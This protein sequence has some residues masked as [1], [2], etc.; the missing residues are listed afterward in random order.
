[1]HENTGESHS[2]FFD[3]MNHEQPTNA[4]VISMKTNKVGSETLLTLDSPTPPLPTLTK[5]TE[6]RLAGAA[7]SLEL[8]ELLLGSKSFP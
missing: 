1:M 6:C 7:G 4:Q 5:G 8:S 3:S 2:E